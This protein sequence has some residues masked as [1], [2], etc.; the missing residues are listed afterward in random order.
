MMALV[1]AIVK[2]R[3]V[4]EIEM[5]NPKMTGETQRVHPGKVSYLQLQKVQ[6]LM[7]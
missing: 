2:V 3:M 4:K 7:V 5:I 1:G 6:N